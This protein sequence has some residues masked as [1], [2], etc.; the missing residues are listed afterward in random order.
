MSQGRNQHEGGSIPVFLLGLFFDP[1]DVGDILFRNA[2]T[3]NGLHGVEVS[4]SIPLR[5]NIMSDVVI[6]NPA[7]YSRGPAFESQHKYWV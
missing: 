4:V 7:L 6:I 2:L 3:C 1:K 5:N